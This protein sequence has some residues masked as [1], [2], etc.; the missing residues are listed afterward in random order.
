[1]G[2][3]NRLIP[4][5]SLIGEDLVNT[6]RFKEDRYLGDPINAVKIFNEKKVDELAIVDIRAT[7]NNTGIQ[8]DVLERI[9][10]QAFMPLSYGGGIRTLEDTKRIFKI[11]F[12]K[13]IVNSIFFDEKAIIKQMINHAGSQSIVFSIDIKKNIFDRYFVYSHSGQKKEVLLDN[14]FLDSV[15][16]MNFGEVIINS[17][18]NDGEMNGYNTELIEK[19]NDRLSMPVIPYGGADNL[20]T[21]NKLFKKMN[22]NAAAATSFFVYQGTNKA[23]LISYPDSVN[24]EK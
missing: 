1:M 15:N 7:V 6:R 19:I 22:I 11:G 21:I 24:L 14:S 13:V 23:V 2:Q 18:D 20:E 10:N 16:D 3:Y 9:A 8:F 17:I 4:V 5:L 12:E